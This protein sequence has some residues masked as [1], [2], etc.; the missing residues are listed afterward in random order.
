MINV[1][2]LIGIGNYSNRDKHY[3]PH[4]IKAWNLLVQWPVFTGD[5]ETIRAICII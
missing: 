3:Y 4:A 1:E 5:T 2:T